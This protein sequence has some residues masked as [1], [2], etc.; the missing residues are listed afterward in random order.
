MVVQVY[1]TTEKKPP[2]SI[3][4]SAWVPLTA[5]LALKKTHT[6]FKLRKPKQGF[7]FLVV[8]ISKAPA[9]AVGTPTAPGHVRVGEVELFPAS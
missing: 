3:T 1:G 7:R 2:A 5:P 6:R 8:W 9:A 4:E